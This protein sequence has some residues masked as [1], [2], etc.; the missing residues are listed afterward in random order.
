MEHH[1]FLD[2]KGL[3]CP[4]PLLKAKKML[5]EMASGEVLLVHSTDPGSMRDF[6]V[7]AKQSE[8]EL[9]KACEESDF[10]LYLLKKA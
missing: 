4:M 2:A 5:N 9:L 8:H 7:F 10:Y 6:E 1:F 3:V